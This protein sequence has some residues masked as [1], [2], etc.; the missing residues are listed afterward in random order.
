MKLE[1]FDS[2]NL[3]V[4]ISCQDCTGWDILGR[5]SSLALIA[6]DCSFQSVSCEISP[7]LP[8]DV[9]KAVDRFAALNPVIRVIEAEAEESIDDEFGFV[10]LGREEGLVCLRNAI[11]DNSYVIFFEAID[12]EVDLASRCAYLIANILGLTS[13]LSYEVR[14]SVYELLNNITEH[15]YE[16]TYHKWIKLKIEKKT[17][18]LSVSI[19]DKGSI[20]DPTGDD[21]FDLDNYLKSNQRRGLGLILTRKIADH[22]KYERVSG[23]NNVYFEKSFNPLPKTT[24]LNGEVKMSQLNVGEP[25]HLPN[26]RYLI[27][28]EGDIDTKGAL[29]M[30]D[31]LTQLLEQHMLNIVLDFEKVPFVSSAG[32][33]I[34][35]GMVNTLRDEGG[36]VLFKNISPKV[37]S[38]FRL[39][40]LDDFFTIAEPE[41]MIR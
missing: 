4:R 20:F 29:V 36:D 13:L 32:V 28:L 38:V 7:K 35:L 25:Q 15:G 41:E 2:S 1:A 18:K 17:D 40:N 8:T 21:Y 9:R 12:A 26:G 37:S 31:L 6:F 19:V 14:F 11:D 33:G 34:L 3:S 5:L 16:S 27:P 23:F 30:E 24:T 22:M 39:L 10:V